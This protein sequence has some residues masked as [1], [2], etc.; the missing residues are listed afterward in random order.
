[1]GHL[2]R[3]KHAGEAEFLLFCTGW[4]RYWGTPAY[5][6]SYLCL[7]G[8][9]ADWLLRQGKKGIGLDTR[10]PGLCDGYTALPLHRRLLDGGILAIENLTDLGRLGMGLVTLCALP[11]KHTDAAGAPIRAV[12]II[13]D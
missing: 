5:F 12:A 8:E 7:D 6:G 11:L 10:G 1:M 4:D 3:Q 2:R 13:N 9:T